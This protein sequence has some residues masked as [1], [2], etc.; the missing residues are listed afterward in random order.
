MTGLSSSFN[1]KATY[2][3]GRVATDPWPAEIV[4]MSGQPSLAEDPAGDPGAKVRAYVKWSL[5]FSE[6]V[7]GMEEGMEAGRQGKV[8]GQPSRLYGIWGCALVGAHVWWVH[9]CG[10]RWPGL[11][12]SGNQANLAPGR[13]APSLSSS[14]STWPMSIC[15]SSSC[16]TCSP[17]SRRSTAE[18]IA[19]DYIHS[20]HNQPTLDLLAL[21]PMSIIS[22]WMRRAASHRCAPRAAPAQGQSPC[23]G[24][25]T[26]A[27]TAAWGLAEQPPPSSL[28]LLQVLASWGK[29]PEPTPHFCSSA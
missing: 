9:T 8:G 23:L 4:S 16:G 3:W 18:S 25:S 20:H 13:A 27:E 22:C 28:P 15:S 14:A 10:A 24:N 17:W 11:G 21:K 7:C 12:C 26:A 19:W 1:T 29:A 5:H 6:S 2:P